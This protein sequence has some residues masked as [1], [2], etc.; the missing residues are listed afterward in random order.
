[1]TKK[2]HNTKWIGIA[3]SVLMFILVI[4]QFVPFWRYQGESLSIAGYIWRPYEHS[5]FTSLFK[6][7][8]GKGFKI[9]LMFAMPMV[10]TLVANT[11]GT[12]LCAIKYS[13]KAVYLLPVVSAVAGIYGYLA[14]P[15]FQLGSSWIIHLVL[16]ILVMAAGACGF[17]VAGNAS[18]V[19]PNPTGM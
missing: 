18:S 16:Y 11:V 6:S 1:M 7:Y 8:F 12:V 9:S 3:V 13:S 4:L 15:A 14:A 17:I 5:E 10:A 2:L 19:H